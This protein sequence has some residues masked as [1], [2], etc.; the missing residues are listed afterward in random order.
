[1]GSRLWATQPF[2]GLLLQH[3]LWWE[4][5]EKASC[6]FTKWGQLDHLSNGTNDLDKNC[7]LF[8]L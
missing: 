3:L 6:F 4:L 7:P 8:E 1:M 2:N 5:H